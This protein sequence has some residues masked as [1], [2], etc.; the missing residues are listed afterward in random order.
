MWGAPLNCSGAGAWGGGLGASRA[1][2]ECWAW[3]RPAGLEQLPGG[4]Q[5]AQRGLALRQARSRVSCPL[6]RPCQTCLCVALR[7]GR[8]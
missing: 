3:L 8:T 5:G 2:G 6:P 4:G 7:G 1:Q